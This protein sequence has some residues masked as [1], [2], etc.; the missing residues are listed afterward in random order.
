MGSRYATIVADPPWS[1]GKFNNFATRHEDRPRKPSEIPYPTM[2]LFEIC[3]VP[4]EKLAEDD[5]HLY[6]WATSAHIQDAFHV[7]H[8]WGFR[9]SKMLVWAKAPMGKGMGWGFH[10]STEFIL[11][12]VRGSLE[13][14]GRVERDWWNWKR[15]YDQR[16]KPRHSAKP[17]AF[18]DVV[19]QVSPGPYLELFARSNRL[20]WDTWGNECLE[21]VEVCS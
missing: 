9:Y 6:L 21:H 1:Y 11:F 10:P 17:D 16:G 4:V 7:A 14:K 5:S 20:G 8:A 19:E 13:V 18:L 2:D 12:C 3:R 15:P